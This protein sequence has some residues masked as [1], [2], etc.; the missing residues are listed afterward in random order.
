MNITFPLMGIASLFIFHHD[1]FT[2]TFYVTLGHGY[3]IKLFVVRGMY[4]LIHAPTSTSVYTW[5]RHQIETFSALLAICAGNSPVTG[6]FPAPRAVTRSFDVFLDLRLNKQLSKH[7]LGWW[8][9]TLSRALWRQCNVN[10][11]WRQGM[12][13]QLHPIL[14]YICYPYLKL[15]AGLA[16]LPLLKRWL[17][18][19]LMTSLE[20][21]FQFT[22][23]IRSVYRF[24]K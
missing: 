2:K 3:V 9:E 5:W 1:V 19:H 4:F 8:F 7:S 18:K 23:S 17:L 22:D 14:E 16:N 10:H 15:D 24:D 12:Y 13:I 20:S 21:I 6:E 11:R